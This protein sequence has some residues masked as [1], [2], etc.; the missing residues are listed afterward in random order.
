MNPE[1]SDV[2]A[3]TGFAH[4]AAVQSDGSVIYRLADGSGH[5]R[6]PAAEWHRLGREFEARTASVR[7][8]TRWL[9]IGLLPATFLY[10]MTFAQVL[11]F[12]GILILAAI[13][14]G[15][16]VICFSH[17]REVGKASNA[18]ENAL[19][20]FARSRPARR[21]P[22]RVPRWLE[23]L[24]LVLVGPHLLIALAGELG[25]PDTFR[26]T[27]FSGTDVGPME[28]IAF[29]LIA[30]RIAWPFLGPRLVGARLAR[31]QE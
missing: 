28:A 20:G 24:F 7:K 29:I 16:L 18:V 27:P 6:L 21:D 4:R 23:I 5:V 31:G 15:P 14:L 13:F 12:G 10:G 1:I 9:R 3:A 11:P 2:L 25:G 26:G 19:A 8:R 30:V 17:A 22:R